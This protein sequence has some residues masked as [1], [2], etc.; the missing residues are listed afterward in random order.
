MSNDINEL[1]VN[2]IGLKGIFGERF[3]DET[4]KSKTAVEAFREAADKFNPSEDTITN[5]KIGKQ[6]QTPILKPRDAEWE[7]APHEPTQMDKLKASA[8]DALIFGGLSLLFFYFQR[9]GQMA[10]SASM[11]CIIACVA[12]G[13]FGVGKNFAGGK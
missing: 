11:P 6:P 1:D 8:K 3:H 2:D 9:S 10:M 5:L 12:L 4:Q 13:A 7:L